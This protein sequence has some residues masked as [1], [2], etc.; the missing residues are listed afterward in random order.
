MCSAAAARE[1]HMGFFDKFRKKHG[2][3]EEKAAPET[4]KAASSSED[5]AEPSAPA[6]DLAQGE[7][8]PEEE[9]RI[10]NE[11]ESDR[12]SISWITRRTISSC[13]F[14]RSVPVS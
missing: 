14:W 11:A 13:R 4:E 1:E 10:L 3:E 8:T 2:H 6:G 9:A 7:M 12:S 5:S